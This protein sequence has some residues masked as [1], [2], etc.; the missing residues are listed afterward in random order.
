MDIVIGNTYYTNNNEPYIVL[1]DVGRRNH[2]KY[3][4]IQFLN[5]GR[6]KEVRA[7]H[8]I[9]GYIK[10]E[11]SF[12]PNKIYINHKG[13]SRYQILEFVE[14]KHRPV[15]VRFI[16]TGAEGIFRLEH[17][18]VGAIRD[19][20]IPPIFGVAQYG[21]T[22]DPNLHNIVRRWYTVWYSMINRCYNPKHKEYKSYGGKGVT[23]CDRWLTFENFLDDIPELLNFENAIRDPYNYQ[24]DKDLLQCEL[25]SGEKVYSPS[26]CVFL[27]TKDN[28]KLRASHNNINVAN[29]LYHNIL[30][31]D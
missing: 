14:G 7:D 16:D 21:N 19:P 28:H 13:N 4:K 25:P 12:D 2:S 29:D 22:I 5:S 23:V 10:D 11:K 3:Y 8:I 31:E 15:R 1:E 27:S 20:S 26:T 18:L 6:I 17:A 24:L 30:L 9:D